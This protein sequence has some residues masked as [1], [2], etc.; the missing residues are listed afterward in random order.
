MFGHAHD[1]FGTEKQEG[2]VF[3]NAAMLDDNYK[4]RRK[5]KLFIL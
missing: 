5:G 3:S 1:A 2:I 4:S